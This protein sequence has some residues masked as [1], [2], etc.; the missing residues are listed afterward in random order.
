MLI[1]HACQAEWENGGLGR[2]TGGCDNFFVGHH[3]AAKLA[4]VVEKPVTRATRASM[5]AIY[6]EAQPAPTAGSI[7][8]LF[9]DSS[10]EEL[11]ELKVSASIVSYVMYIDSLS[12]QIH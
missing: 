1:H 3:P 4:A 7:D 8:A 2:E 5:N 6:K 12:I 9:P 11:S 10:E